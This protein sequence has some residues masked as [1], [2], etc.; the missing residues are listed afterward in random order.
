[1]KSIV[2]YKS[3]YGSSGQYAAWLAEALHCSAE[4]INN[5]KVN[6][7]LIYDVIVYVGGLYA[8]SVNGYKKFSENLS[9]LLGKKLI[10][11]MVGNT[12]PAETEKY[13]QVFMKNVPEEYRNAVKPFALR[14]DQLFSKMS[15]MHRLMMK[16]PKSMAEK[17][18]VEQ[19]T[20]DDKQFIENYGKD[21]YFVNQESINE[22]VEYIKK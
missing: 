21:V 7:L 11:C 3:K 12:N 5:V 22:I 15:V 20:E 19:R 4:D 1:M 13:N 10:L 6:E 2:I 16:L 8:G 9:S 17:I 18:P 14:G